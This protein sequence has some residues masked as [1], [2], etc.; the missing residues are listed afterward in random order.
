MAGSGKSQVTFV[1]STAHERPAWSGAAFIVEAMLLLLI[2]IGSLAV[3]T[4]LFAASAERATASEELSRAVAAASTAA[5]RF[6]ADPASVPAS[7]EGEGL[8]T[9]CEVAEEDRAGG[10]LYHAQISVANEEGTVVYQVETS[11]YVSEGGQ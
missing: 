4:Q 7:S 2:L 9:T 3:F 1:R 5:E 8:T 10:V 11:R 6:A